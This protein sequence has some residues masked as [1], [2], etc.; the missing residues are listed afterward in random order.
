MYS[1]VN[2]AARPIA[3]EAELAPLGFGQLGRFGERLV[4]VAEQPVPG[5][6]VVGPVLG[7]LGE[8]FLWRHV[9]HDGLSTL[10][11]A[12]MRTEL[13]LTITRTSVIC[14]RE[15]SSL[16]CEAKLDSTQPV[17]CRN[18]D[19]LLIEGKH[20]LVHAETLVFACPRPWGTPPSKPVTYAEP[21]SDPAPESK[22]DGARMDRCLRCGRKLRSAAGIAQGFGDRCRARVIAAA[23]VTPLVG[24]SKTQ[25]DKAA[26]LIG[27]KGIVPT[28]HAG[29]W[30]TVS[31]KGDAY[32]LTAPEACNC[33]AGL[34]GRR[35][36]HSAA[37]TLMAASL[38]R[39]A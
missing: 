35:C 38:R 20:G 30:R 21:A 5:A 17:R 18:C 27:D 3:E 26:E 11:E 10:R 31:S 33:R 24:W 8:A 2:L 16:T 25:T 13:T 28:G 14:V 29:V 9:D 7:D 34:N 12:S 6:V 39:A 36:Y 32:Y 1:R 23:K 15:V 22:V 4:D 37:A 19:G